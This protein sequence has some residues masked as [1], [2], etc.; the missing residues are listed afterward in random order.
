MERLD[1]KRRRTVTANTT[2]QDTLSSAS[3]YLSQVAGEAVTHMSQKEPNNIGV[4][5]LF[6]CSRAMVERTDITELALRTGFRGGGI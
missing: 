5:D 2:V 1:P 3:H 4:G 6:S